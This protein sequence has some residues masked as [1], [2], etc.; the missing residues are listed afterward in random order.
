MLWTYHF[1]WRLSPETIC[2]ALWECLK[3]VD[4]WDSI[5][6]FAFHQLRSFPSFRDLVLFVHVEG[7]NHKLMAMIMWTL[8]YQ[9]NQ[10]RV[11][12]KEFL[13]SQVIPQVSQSLSDFKIL[14]PWSAR[15]VDHTNSQIQW[16]PPPSGSLKINFDGAMF[17]ELGMAGLGVVKTISFP[18]ELCLNSFILEGDS[19]TLNN[20]QFSQLYWKLSFSLWSHSFFGKIHF[21][22]HNCISF[23]HVRKLGHKPN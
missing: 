19:T 16:S 7:K 9:R 23:S 8:W 17:P 18:Q 15:H 21:S 5:P 10:L 1:S 13:I 2:H 14:L 20:D 12:L 22:Y 3:L 4:V 6:N 11:G